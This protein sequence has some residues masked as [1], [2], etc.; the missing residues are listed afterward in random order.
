MEFL[1]HKRLLGQVVWLIPK[2]EAITASKVEYISNT[3]FLISLFGELYKTV[4][5]KKRPHDTSDSQNY[6][7]EQGKTIEKAGLN[8]LQRCQVTDDTVL[9]HLSHFFVLLKVLKHRATKEST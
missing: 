2:S 3:T 5:H 7:L 4:G 9:M 8:T 6:W 1:K